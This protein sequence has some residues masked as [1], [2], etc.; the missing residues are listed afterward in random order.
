MV[1]VNGIHFHDR[2]AE[3]SEKDFLD[4]F[5]KKFKSHP[6][7]KKRDEKQKETWLKAAYLSIK[8]DVKRRKEEEKKKPAGGK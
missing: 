4:K 7:F 6:I 5:M 2:F 3:M 8:E 1:N